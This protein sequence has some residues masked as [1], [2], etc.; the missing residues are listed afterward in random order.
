MTLGSVPDTNVSMT[1]SGS[2]H[3]ML[4]IVSNSRSSCQIVARSIRQA[5]ESGGAIY[6]LGHSFLLSLQGSRLRF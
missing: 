2:Q 4:R 5:I 1:Y 3:A 6:W